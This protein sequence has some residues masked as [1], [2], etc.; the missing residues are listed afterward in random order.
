[1]RKLFVL[2][3][4][5]LFIISCGEKVREEITERFDN[6]KP[7]KIMKFRG[8]GSE[9]VMIE[10]INYGSKGDTLFWE[11][12]LEDF[13]YEK[14]RE[15]IAE[16]FGNGQ[17]KYS[18][19]YIGEDDS[20][21]LIRTIKYW[22]DGQKKFEATFKDGKEDGLLN[23]WNYDGQKN[24]EAT[25]KDGKQI[26]KTNWYYY[27]NGQKERERTWK[28]DEVIRNTEWYENGQK[29][30]EATYK[31][32]YTDG[33][34]TGWYENGQKKTKG[35]FK[36]SSADSIW[37]GW[38][39]DGNKK[40]EHEF[41]QGETVGISKF[42]EKNTGDLYMGS[43]EQSLNDNGAILLYLKKNKKGILTANRLTP[44]NFHM[45]PQHWLMKAKKYFITGFN[46]DGVKD[47][48]YDGDKNI[49]TFFYEDGSIR[50]VLKH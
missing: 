45:I 8:E 16:R 50:E 29:K 15:E 18:N 35:F 33:L 22:Y 14:V 5:I 21:E 17:K 43:T 10:K 28:D 41:K 1:M 36:R 12:P 20:E 42:W 44:D 4:L 9:E 23:E 34:Y 2:S 24:S 31:D 40:I 13:Y 7:K 38:Y 19:F 6:G 26:E 37:T 3:T 25:Y 27:E 47:N 30:F 32:G 48:Y 46:K 11:K 39:K 49:T